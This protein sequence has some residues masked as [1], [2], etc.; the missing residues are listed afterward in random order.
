[1]PAIHCR[2]SRLPALPWLAL[3]ALSLPIPADAADDLFGEPGHKVIY[4]L[5]KADPEYMESVLFS[6]G[7]LMRKYGDDIHIVIT[8]IGP[9]LHLL[10][11]L[12]E[13]P[14]PE[15]LQ[16]RAGSL[17]MY[18]VE[19]HACGNTMTA[20]SWSEDDLLDFATVVPIGADDLMLYQE[21][22]YA[23]ISW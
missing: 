22:G 3:L 16:E 4:Q 17:A 11:K 10:G 21:K 6:A 19:F 14:V 9:G 13:R 20:L 1:M 7:E 12:P 18:G 15:L 2:I 8:A 5:N 23:Y